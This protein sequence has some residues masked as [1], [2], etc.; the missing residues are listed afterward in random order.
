M[1]PVPLRLLI[2]SATLRHPVSP[3]TFQKPGTYAETRLKRVRVEPAVRTSKTK[4]NT[5]RAFSAVLI[6][7]STR[8]LPRGTDFSLGDRLVFEGKDYEVGSIERLYDASRL[9][10]LEIGLM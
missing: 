8:S 7:D 1:R 9:H 6:F 10:H 4:D 2:H 3:D 5:E